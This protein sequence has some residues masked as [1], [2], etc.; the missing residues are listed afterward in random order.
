MF[1]FVRVR[2]GPTHMG[3]SIWTNACQHCVWALIIEAF[4]AIDIEIDLYNSTAVASRTRRLVV[5]TIGCVTGGQ[6]RNKSK[7]E[8]VSHIGL[9][10]RLMSGL[11]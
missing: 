4:I 9:P 3:K 2:T 11:E 10:F 5:I 8:K 6:Q 1:L 7:A